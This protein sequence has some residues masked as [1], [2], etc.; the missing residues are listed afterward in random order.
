VRVNGVELYVEDTRGP[1][2]AV[3][4]SHGL[5]WSTKMWRFQVAAFRGAHRCIAFDH[6]G[7]GKSEITASGYDMDTLA[8]DAGALIEACGAAP[9]HFVGLSMGGFVGMRLAARR[10]ELLRSLVLLCTTSEGELWRKIPG[11]A[12][13]NFLT[14]FVGARPFLPVILKLMFARP[15]RKD[16]ARADLRK[17]LAQEL[18][19][20]DVVGMRRAVSGVMFRKPVSAAEL[21]RIRVPTL[22]ISGAEDA[23]IEPKRS[24]RTASRI[25]GAR[26]L[27]IPRAGHS[28]CLEEPDAVNRALRDFW[29]SLPAE[30]VVFATNPG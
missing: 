23:A 16:P 9:V 7:Q 5:L 27:G 25:P 12:A 28:A 20:N 8:A 11:Y 19:G 4:F 6:R 1:G 14:R 30:K 3:V 24:M 18:L 26:F 22:V 10:P 29:Q 15:F 2:P 21:A 13:M 17:S